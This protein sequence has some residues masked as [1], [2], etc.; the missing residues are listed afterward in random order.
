[1]NINW[2]KEGNNTKVVDMPNVNCTRQ[3][4]IEKNY[5][6]KPCRAKCLRTEF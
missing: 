2:N 6:L 1:M 4:G 5:R 3:E